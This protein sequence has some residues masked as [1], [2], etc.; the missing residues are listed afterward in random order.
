MEEWNPQVS[1]SIIESWGFPDEV[2]E[3]A[4]PASYVDPGANSAATFADVMFVSK[5]LVDD[6][7][8]KLSAVF[9]DSPSCRRLGVDEEAATQ[10]M[11]AY[12]DKLKSMQQLLA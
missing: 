4:D 8:T 9:A 2:A 1:K 3:S 7:D 11:L 10:M 12:R 5:L 6:N